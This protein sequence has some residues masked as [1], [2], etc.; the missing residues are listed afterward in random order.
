MGEIAP[1]WHVGLPGSISYY[2]IVHISFKHLANSFL[3]SKL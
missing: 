1:E 3:T 2:R